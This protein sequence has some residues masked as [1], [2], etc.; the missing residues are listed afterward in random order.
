MGEI[1]MVDP[2]ISQNANGMEAT[3]LLMAS[4]IVM[5]II[6]TGLGMEGVMVE[7][8]IPPNVDLTEVAACSSMKTTQ[9][10]MLVFHTSLGMEY[11]TMLIMIIMI[12]VL[13]TIPPNA[14]LTEA[15]VKCFR[16]INV[17][18]FYT[19]NQCI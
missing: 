5:L 3:A 15:T 11:V 1:V 12:M 16:K 7:H 14:D 18:Y 8:T 9:T 17:T 13:I 2:T 10:V 19:I 4:R 6:H